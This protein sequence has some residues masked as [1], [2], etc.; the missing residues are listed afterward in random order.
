MLPALHTPH[1]RVSIVQDVDACLLVAVDLVASDG[2]F[3]VSK[4][5]NSGTQT[6]VY[7]VTLQRKT[8]RSKQSLNLSVTRKSSLSCTYKSFLK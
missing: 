6:A 8:K 1:Y 7:S 5:N 4:D 2:T 3:P